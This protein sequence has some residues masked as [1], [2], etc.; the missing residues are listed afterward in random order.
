MYTTHRRYSAYEHY[1]GHGQMGGLPKPPPLNLGFQV[2]GMIEGVYSWRT[3]SRANA[4]PAAGRTAK[5][6]R[7]GVVTDGWGLQTPSNKGSLVERLASRKN[8]IEQV[9]RAAFPAETTA[10]ILST[11]RVSKSDSGHLFSSQK[12][13]RSC[14]R[15]YIEYAD[16]WLSSGK[17]DERY[18]PYYTGDVW[19]SDGAAIPANTGPYAFNYARETWPAHADKFPTSTQ[20]QGV[21]NRFFAA[22][23][24]DRAEASLGVTAIELLRGDIP[25]VLKNYRKMIDD[26]QSIQNSFGSEYLNI[27]FG[28]TPLINEAANIIK[29]GMTLERAAYYESF[30]RKRQW[31]GPSVSETTEGELVIT[32]SNSPYLAGS[33]PLG[34]APTGQSS[35]IG[36]TVNRSKTSLFSED[37][38][39]SSRYTGL[40]KP[41]LRANSHSD[42][43]MDIV[44]RLGLVPDSTLVWD[45]VPYSWLVDW[46]TTMGASITNARVYSPKSGKY[47]TDYAYLTTKRT[48]QHDSKVNYITS[49]A[50]NAKLRRLSLQRSRSYSV[51]VV[52]WRDRATPFGF[53]TQ[54]GS[55][56]GSQF[57]ILVALG[58]AQTR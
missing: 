32:N 24:P 29:I 16:R 5:R 3:G 1:S 18:F 57:A 53:G 6:N 40:A 58:L 20:R 26:V 54:M 43:A 51:N 30:R 8:Y 47:N 7:D 33:F 36:F 31:E 50:P 48:V 38:H 10:G 15:G 27:M 12:I 9:Q 4:D 55:L 35:G 56:N 11:N 19:A 23:A 37:Y 46:F 21:A 45:L 25:S 2:P 44:K 42:R 13:F 52:K 28:W 49:V 17:P 14:F 41:T 22:T 39:F 34:G